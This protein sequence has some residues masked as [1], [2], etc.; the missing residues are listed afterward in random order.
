MGYYSDVAL[1]LS[2]EGANQLAKALAG[3]RSTMSLEDRHEIQN[4]LINPDRKGKNKSTGTRLYFWSNIKWYSTFV[5]VA[6]IESFLDEL[7]GEHYQLLRIGED[8]TDVESCGGFYSNYFGLYVS[9]Q[10]HFK[11]AE[12]SE[13]A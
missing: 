2:K 11:H 9:H 4:L 10:I 8:M 5:E 13:A 1:C 3:V 7:D 6:F 12:E